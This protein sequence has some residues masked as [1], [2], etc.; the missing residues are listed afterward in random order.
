MGRV[1]PR[2]AVSGSSPTSRRRPEDELLI[3]CARLSLPADVAARVREIV[4]GDV[5]W[6]HVVESARRN[7]VT[8]FLHRHLRDLPIPADAAER[9]RARL[10]E[11]AH[12]ALRLSGEL[13]R[14]LDALA[15]GG[16]DALAYKG[17]ALAVQTYGDLSLRPYSDLDLLVRPSDAPQACAVLESLGYAPQL[18][19]SPAQDAFFRRVDGDYQH[20]H[21]QTGVLVEL[22][23]RVSSER[24][25]MPLETEALMRRA[26]AVPLGG[27]EVR[28]P[29]PDDLLL[30]LLIHGAKHRWKR[31]EWVSAVAELLRA[32]R[33]DVESIVG[34]A[35]DLHA[36]RTALLGLGLARRLLDAPLPVSVIESIGADP[37]LAGMMDEAEGRM[38]GPE[39]D[40]AADTAANLRY[41]LRAR[42]SA[43]DR[44]RY[45]WR[46]ATLPTP[47]DW[48]A[49]HLP[50]A[51]F[52]LYRVLRPARLLLRYGRRGGDAGGG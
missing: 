22:H 12:R 32:G 15:A 51:L 10:R 4:S 11:D 37:D 3:A 2:P 43:V 13:R 35:T 23:C 50:D 46:W 39:P 8:A 40:D 14:L 16:I 7:R 26:V 34:R 41:N 52:P 5:D 1:L 49:R 9:I 29:H 24:F 19:L 44:A 31:L 25:L 38:F 30:I 45:V 42:D 17:P 21:P 18:H 33:T 20:V 6:D 27:T 28:A 48:A 47:E 36:R